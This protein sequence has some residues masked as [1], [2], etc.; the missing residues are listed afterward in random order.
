MSYFYNPTLFDQ[1]HVYSN[2][3]PKKNLL[4]HLF[5][6]FLHFLSYV[7]CFAGF[8]INS[9]HFLVNRWKRKYYYFNFKAFLFGEQHHA[10][11]SLTKTQA[12]FIFVHGFKVLHNNL[13]TKQ[14]T[15]YNASFNH[16]TS[17]FSV[18]WI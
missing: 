14:Q 6:T 17:S 11:T 7:L 10:T 2:C 9:L 18:Y 12:I 16:D 1:F 5:Y 8:G 3:F 15:Y 4:E 13:Y